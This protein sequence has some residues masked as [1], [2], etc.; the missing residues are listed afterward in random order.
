MEM[1]NEIEKE[2][3]VVDDNSIDEENEA[4]NDAG[5]V[6]NTDS[7]D[8]AEAFCSGTDEETNKTEENS[9][10]EGTMT[11]NATDD[12]SEDSALADADCAGKKK[13]A[14]A[15][16]RKRKIIL[17]VVLS[18]LAIFVLSGIIAWIVLNAKGRNDLYDKAKSSAP[19]MESIE[20]EE[21]QAAEAQNDVTWK[22]GWV[23]YNGDIYQ[24]NEDIL[25][26]LVMGIDKTGKV[27]TVESGV[28]GGQADLIMLAVF[29]PHTKNV[30]LI[31]INRNTM[32]EIDVYDDNGDY[33]GSGQGQICLQHGYG[34]GAELSC[35]RTEK[36]VSNLFYNLPIHGYLSINMGAIK[37][38]NSAVGGVTI[39]LD[40][41]FQAVMDGVSVF[42]PK[43][44]NTLTDDEAYVYI[45]YRDHSEFD[46]ATTRLNRQKKYIA[47]LISKLKEETA[48][49]FTVPINVF[50][51]LLPYIVTDITTSEITYMVSNTYGYSFNFNN[52]YSLEGTTTIGKT[53]H[54]EFN[55]DSEQLYNM[56]IDIFYEKVE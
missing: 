52:I 4:V 5:P 3:G 18:V 55:Y 1:S 42:L 30:S 8:K 36:A 29:N 33:I 45:R 21:S 50:N 15:K 46:S 27:K 43:G 49:D 12:K 19:I 32:T 24:Y 53:E 22:K 44:D 23:R 35:E 13:D 54:E 38:I 51:E 7:F 6:V 26:F 20:P 16:K 28:D 41:D 37:A 25:T 34:D 17:T 39:T 9:V 2:N 31:T 56:I 40:D 11:E 10:I 48:K 14:K 47:A